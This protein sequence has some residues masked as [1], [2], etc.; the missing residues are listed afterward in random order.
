MA[1][2][3]DIDYPSGFVENGIE[4]SPKYTDVEVS[5]A[6]STQYDYSQLDLLIKPQEPVLA[7]SLLATSL[8]ASISRQE[9]PLYSM[10]LQLYR[11][12]TK[13]RFDIPTVFWASTA[14]FRL[15]VDTFPANS[16]I[17][18]VLAIADIDETK[19][20]NSD[21]YPGPW[22]IGKDK[23]W[24]R[25]ENHPITDDLFKARP[26]PQSVTISGSYVAFYRRKHVGENLTVEKPWANVIKN[27]PLQKH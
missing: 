22:T 27:L 9:D 3:N 15:R 19:T 23:F 17:N 16:H 24:F 6:N 1:F 20:Q 2:S 25:W 7:A 13:Q 26:E 14:G 21:Y 4:W 11:R 8:T 18:V 12:S 5:L 10:H